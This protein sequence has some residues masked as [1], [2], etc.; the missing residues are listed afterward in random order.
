MDMSM[1]RIVDSLQRIARSLEK[2]EK[3]IAEDK[4]S[5]GGITFKTSDETEEQRYEQT[6]D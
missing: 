2:I 1:T 5:F 6:Y 3:H 4:N